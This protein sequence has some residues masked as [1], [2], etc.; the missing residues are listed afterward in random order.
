MIAMKFGGTSVGTAV[1]IRQACRLIGAELKRKPLVIV[2]AHNSPEFR[3]TDALVAAAKSARDGKPDSQL[4][5][6]AQRRL[7]G[8][9]GID[10]A[11][12][13]IDF[14]L[15]QFD[16]LLSGIA[17]IGELTPRTMDVVMSFGERMSGRVLNEVLG[18]DFG[19]RSVYRSSISLGLRTDANF[20]AAHP[21]PDCYPA[22]AKQIAGL[23]FEALVTTGFIA[24]T[25]DGQITTLGRGGS[26]Y[27]A[28]IF[29][30]I[31][32]AEEVQIW[33]DVSGVMTADP[34]LAP[35]ARSI[36]ELTFME[37]SELAWYGAKVLHPATMIPAIESDIPVLVKNTSAPD[38][39]GTII[40]KRIPSRRN[41]DIV[42]SLA[43]LKGMAMIT[44]TTGRMFGSHGFMSKIFEVFNRHSVDV[45]MIATSEVTVSVTTPDS[46]NIESAAEAIRNFAEVKVERGFSLVSVVGEL[47]RGTPG[48]AA[49]VTRAMA[50]GGINIRMIS[51]GASEINIAL[52]VGDSQMKRAITELHREFFG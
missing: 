31:V 17:M 44:V 24:S 39:P 42:K 19:I 40:R 9:L 23:D 21:D 15:D 37:A 20:G 49:R 11:A 28:T 1:N 13:G 7:C 47:M 25:R 5:F 12:A 3:M 16:K 8:E 43:V 32:G 52:V 26:D 29:G 38:H 34:R 50:A 10:S 14:L 6:T 45:H 36:P 22:V 18:R 2:S 27:S 48:V 33:T 46:E 30:A 35:E 51:Q 4:I 41:A